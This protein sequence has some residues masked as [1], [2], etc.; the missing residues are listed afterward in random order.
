MSDLSPEFD[1]PAGCGTVNAVSEDGVTFKIEELPKMTFNWHRLH[2]LQD[3]LKQRC[4]DR[5]TH[6]DPGERD[7]GGFKPVPGFTDSRGWTT[8]G[9]RSTPSDGKW[10]GVP[11][12]K[13]SNG[14]ESL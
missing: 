1:H 2:Q 14:W 6:E 7:E 13:D 3:E 9:T 4:G 5:R 10:H 8:G 12:F 11:G